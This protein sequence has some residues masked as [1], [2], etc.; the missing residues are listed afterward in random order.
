MKSLLTAWVIVIACYGVLWF[1]DR[2]AKR[3]AEAE[4]FRWGG[5]D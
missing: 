4:D 1:L 3:K 2:R 5:T